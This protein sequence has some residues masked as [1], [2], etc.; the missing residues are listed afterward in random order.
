M[1]Q[2]A[3]MVEGAA[4]PHALPEAQRRARSWLSA[5]ALPATPR[6]TITRAIEASAGTSREALAD[7]WEA[8]VQLVAPGADLAAR[9]E[10]RR[11]SNHLAP[12][13]P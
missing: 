12:A 10:L 5:L 6:L 9:A 8:V 4:G 13:V 2:A 11:V 3:R 1:M 7:A